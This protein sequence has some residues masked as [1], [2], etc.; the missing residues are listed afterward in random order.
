MTG[1][2][3][4]TYDNDDGIGGDYLQIKRNGSVLK[5]LYTDSTRLYS[6]PIV[7]GDV[8]SVEF[9]DAPPS[10]SFNINLIRKDF[11]NDDE[12]GD[13]GIKETTITPVLG[14]GDIYTFTATTINGSYDFQYLFDNETIA[15]YQIW[16]EASEPILTEN[17]DYI[18]QQY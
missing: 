6:I 11:T 1:S 8:V 5:R 13:R 10:T 17:N 15:N 18:N 7:V 12:D 9:F 4:V 16:T 2:F 3:I 14:P